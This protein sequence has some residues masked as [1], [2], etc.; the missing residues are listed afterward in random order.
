MTG[1]IQR[2]LAIGVLA[3]AVAGA[4]SGY[5]LAAGGSS[6]S[7]AAVRAAKD[8]PGGGPHAAIGA[9]VASYVGLTEAQVRAQLEA[10]KSL[11]DIAKAQGKTVAGLETA[12]YNAA[13]AD[14][15]KAVAAGKLTASEESTRLADLKSHLDDIVNRTGP[16]PGGPGHGPGGPGHAAIAAAVASYLGLTDAQVRTQLQAGNS[17]GQIATAQGK[18]VA[19]LKTAIYNA[20][21]ADLDK[22]VTAGKITSAE[23]STRLADLQSHLDD[24]VNRTGPPGPPHP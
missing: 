7:A 1:K 8:G 24:I 17:L 5:A 18:T 10:G 14:M 15:D 20:V 23:E 19:G 3:L 4:G 16:P 22:A 6:S 13:K 12:I 11:A 2:R 21:K 9:A